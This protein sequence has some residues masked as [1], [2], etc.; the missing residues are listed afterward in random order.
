MITAS[1]AAHSM[2]PPPRATNIPDAIRGRSA[3]R[4]A[5]QRWKQ[6]FVA[7]AGVP[8][9][10]CFGSRGE[11]VFGILM[12]HRVVNRTPGVPAPTYNVPPAQF[13]RQLA[14]LLRR[15]FVAWPLQRAIEASRL[16]QNIPRDVFVVTFDDGY[17]NVHRYAFPILQELNIPATV[18]LATAYLDSDAPFPSDDWSA[19]GDPR[20]PPVAWRPLTIAQCREMQQSGLIE[21][22][23]HTHTHADFRRK[24]QFLRDDLALSM[25]SLREKF[26]IEEPTFAFPY[27][28]KSM[29]FSGPVLAAAAREAGVKCSLTTE[30]E[31]VRCGSDPFDWGRFTAEEFDSPGMLAAKL[32]GWYGILREGWRWLKARRRRVVSF[33]GVNLQAARLPAN[34]RPG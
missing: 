4:K 23:T 17:E 34:A 32:D 31:L 21:L 6:R 29:E 14:G 22:A 9:S 18:F 8:F 28:T 3:F 15:G 13:R 24:P 30:A 2:E 26:G 20:V 27:G 11:G 25:A 7:A 5:V 1:P 33:G 16:G 12:Y 19:A 10:R